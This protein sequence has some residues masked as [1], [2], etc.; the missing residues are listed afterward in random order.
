MKKWWIVTSQTYMRQ[1]KSWS[2]FLLVLM[3][4]IFLGIGV[5]IGYLGMNSSTNHDKIAMVSSNEQLRQQYIKQNKDDIN[6][7]YKTEAS[8]KKA[9]KN[10]DISGYILIK[11]DAKQVTA[12]YYGDQNLSNDVKTNLQLFLGQI[13]Q[14]NNLQN[15][16][17]SPAQATS[18]ATNF[19]LKEH[20]QKQKSNDSTIRQVSFWIMVGMVYMILINYSSITAQEI[21]SEKGTKIKE[22]IFSSTSAVKY[23]IGKISGVM[24][25]ILTQIVVYIVG[26]G[27]V[28]EIA[29]KI[30]LTKDFMQNNSQLVNGVVDNL[31][32]VNLLFLFLG[33]VIYTV[34]SALSGALV[35]K[36][37]DAPKAAQPAI[38]LSMLAF[39]ATFPFVADPDVVIVKVLSYV[40]FFSSY[41]MPIRIINETAG[42]VE[43]IISLVILLATIL[44]SSYYIGKMYKGLMLQTD[45]RGFFKAL[46]TGLSYK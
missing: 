36:A 12:N 22:I 10:K 3:P 13:Q 16:Q 21:A 43:V 32:N 34:L 18:L 4:F 14:S 6:G 46:K 39:F 26:G 31:F 42:P 9:L 1:V 23:F 45:D 30:D 8:A 11:S 35:A 44:L 38:M 37:E 20:V 40:P 25:V 2:F 24:L 17:L 19:S 27:I 33:V 15:A 41:F 5:G 29:K 7:K 28:L